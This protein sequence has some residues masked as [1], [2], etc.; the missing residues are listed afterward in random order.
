MIS[1]EVLKNLK[2]AG[3]RELTISLDGLKET[4][5]IIRGN[6]VF[7]HTMDAIMKALAYDGIA[8]SVA[9]TVTALNYDQIESFVNELVDVGVEKFYFFRY[10]DNSNSEYLH[11]SRQALECAS[12]SIYHV[13]QL[14]Q[15]VTFV[16]EG[17]SFYTKRWCNSLRKNE[18]CNFLKGVMSIDYCGNVVVCAAI[19]KALGNIF[20]EKLEDIYRNVQLEQEAIRCIPVACQACHYRVVC[21]GG[22]KSYSYHTDGAY[23]FRDVFCY[24]HS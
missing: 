15:N 18:G 20:V 14:F 23:R 6:G 12:A 8:V 13:S 24:L 21:H 9:F 5:D 16:H 22:C 19:N 4:H 17:F 11:L 7:Q 2:T 1:D 3:L 10:C